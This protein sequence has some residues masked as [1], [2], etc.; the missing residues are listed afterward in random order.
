MVDTDGVNDVPIRGYGGISHSNRFGKA[1]SSDVNSY[2]CNSLSVDINALPDNF[3]ATRSVVQATLTEGAVGYHQANRWIRPL[4]CH[5]G[6]QKRYQTGI[7][8]DNGSVWII[9]IKLGQTMHVLGMAKH[10]VLFLCPNGYRR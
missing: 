5:R 10:S 8:N 3:Y 7:V 2:Y 4:W 1:V 9:G 6:E